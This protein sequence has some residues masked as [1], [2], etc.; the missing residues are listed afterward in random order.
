VS[1]RRGRCRGEAEDITTSVLRTPYHE[2]G[3]FM[4]ES[5]WFGCFIVAPGLGCGSTLSGSVAAAAEKQG[6]GAGGT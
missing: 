4:Q 1:R 3:R 5:G 6:A 2:G